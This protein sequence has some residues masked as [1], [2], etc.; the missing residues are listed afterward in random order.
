MPGAARSS[1]G[2]AGPDAQSFAEGHNDLT[3]APAQEKLRLRPGR[4]NHHD[5]GG[6]RAVVWLADH[7]ERLGANRLPP[8]KR[9]PDEML[10]SPE[11]IR[12]SVDCHKQKGQPE[13]GFR[14]RGSKVR[15]NG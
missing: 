7:P 6:N 5:F 8:M 15:P 14:P 1:A 11:I 3:V 2:N 10:S 4:L 13:Q 9:S 12:S